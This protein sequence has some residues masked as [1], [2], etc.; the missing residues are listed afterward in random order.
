[1]RLEEA[2]EEYLIECQ[3]RN[4][5]ANTVKAKKIVLSYFVRV[6]KEKFDINDVKN[7]KAMHMKWFI[8]EQQKKY[9][10]A[11]TINTKIKILKSFFKYLDEE[12]YLR[13]NPM[14]KIKLLKAEKAKF[15]VFSDNDI[16]KM[17]RVWKGNSYTS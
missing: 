2:I 16:K 8:V 1:M 10:K 17:L 12:G 14:S 9:T 7:I 15:T 5:S 4:Y 3:I 6:V 13:V 11:S